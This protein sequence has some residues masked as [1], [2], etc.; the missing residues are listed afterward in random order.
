MNFK[1]LLRQ[2]FCSIRLS[3]SSLRLKEYYIFY[4]NLCCEFICDETLFNSLK[5]NGYYIY[6]LVHH[7][8]TLHSVHSVYLCFPVRFL[9]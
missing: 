7:T 6:H 2:N 5:N 3:I 4:I 8:K 9:Q 1:T